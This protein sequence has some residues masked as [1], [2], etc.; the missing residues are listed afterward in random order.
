MVVFP[1]IHL[2]TVSDTPQPGDIG[3]P[4]LI[5][6]TS[7][8]LETQTQGQGL[9]GDVYELTVEDA[10]TVTVALSNHLV[11]KIYLTDTYET[12]T[13]SFITIPISDELTSRFIEQRQRVM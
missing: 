1:Q 13:A 9:T 11:G 3:Q 7:N 2:N 8:D 12:S 4:L 6:R 10:Q 5:D